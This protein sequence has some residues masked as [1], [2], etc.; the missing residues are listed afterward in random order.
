VIAL[1]QL[2]REFDLR[3]RTYFRDYFFRRSDAEDVI[4]SEAWQEKRAGC[5]D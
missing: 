5:R 2:Q 1:P 4:L 3:G